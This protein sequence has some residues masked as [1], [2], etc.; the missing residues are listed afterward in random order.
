MCI[1]PQQ[2]NEEYMIVCL[3][4]L[5]VDNLLREQALFYSFYWV[6]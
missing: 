5:V 3:I 6:S 2:Q 4:L 1:L